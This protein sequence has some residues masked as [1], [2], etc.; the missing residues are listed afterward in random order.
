VDDVSMTGESPVTVTVSC[1]AATES[2]TFTFAVKPI[3]MM[4]PSRL[5]VLNPGSSNER[6]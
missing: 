2:S 6:L 3:V 1:T 4:M 5:S